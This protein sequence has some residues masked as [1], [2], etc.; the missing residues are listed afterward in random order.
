MVGRGSESV[1][2]APFNRAFENILIIVIQSENKTAVD[3]NAKGMESLY[4]LRIITFEVLFFI[5]LVKIVI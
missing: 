1:G 3:H 2:Y 4:S 5:A